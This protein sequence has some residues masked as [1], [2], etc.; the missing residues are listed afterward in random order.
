MKKLR[1]A[2][3]ACTA[4]AAFAGPLVVSNAGPAAARPAI[5]DRIERFARSFELAGMYRHA[6]SVWDYAKSRGC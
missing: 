2:L 3:L 4:A 1:S 5:C 6:D